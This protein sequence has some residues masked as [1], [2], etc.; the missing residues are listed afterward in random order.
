MGTTGRAEAA[1]PLAHL[2]GRLRI[3][4]E[5]R[6]GGRVSAEVLDHVAK[7]LGQH[8]SLSRT[9]RGDH[10]CTARGMRHGGQLV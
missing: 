8:P 2:A 1:A 6:H 7:A 10:P 5:R 3:E 9:R 4:G